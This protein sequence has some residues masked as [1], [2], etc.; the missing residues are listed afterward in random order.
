MP[1]RFMQ[2]TST[3]QQNAA[4]QLVDGTPSPIEQN[5]E[6]RAQY[7]QA[8][9]DQRL[10]VVIGVAGITQAGKST[11]TDALVEEHGFVPAT[12]LLPRTLRDNEGDG[13]KPWVSTEI[14]AKISTSNSEVPARFDTTPPKEILL[15]DQAFSGLY[16]ISA[17]NVAEQ[18]LKG[19]ST[20]VI[21]GR[22]EENYL[23]HEGARE[24]IPLVPI[25]VIQLEVPLKI[26]R[27]R[28]LNAG[29]IDPA[30]VSK[31]LQAMEDFEIGDQ[32]Q[33][34][35]LAM[36]LPVTTVMN[37][38]AAEMQTFR[39]CAG[40]IKPLGKS[41]IADLVESLSAEIRS[42]AA[43]Y[44]QDLHRVRVLQYGTSVIPDSVVQV[45][46]DNL[47][48]ALNQNCLTPYLCGGLAVA[49][50]MLGDNQTVRPVSPDIDFVLRTDTDLG[51]SPINM[52]DRL[53]AALLDLNCAHREIK[54]GGWNPQY[55]TRQAKSEVRSSQAT[56]E[57]K[58]E[59]DCLLAIRLIPKGS[60]FCFELPLDQHA[61]F[62]RRDVVLPNGNTVPLAPLEHLLVDKLIMGRGQEIAKFDLFDCAGLL[63]RGPVDVS[64]VRRL[65]DYQRY[66]PGLDKPMQELVSKGQPIGFDELCL[67]LNVI[68]PKMKS[69]LLWANKPFAA[70]SEH[71]NGS[72]TLTLDGLKRLAMTNRLVNSL[73]R[74]LSERDAE[75]ALGAGKST[76]IADAYNQSE[77]NTQANRLKEFLLYYVEFI[78]EREELYVM[79]PA[80]DLSTKTG[81]FR[82]LEGQTRRLLG[83]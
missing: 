20:A 50:Y 67:G 58:V 53:S 6:I 48:P 9:I 23:L 31:R 73:N 5:A 37:V 4:F 38:T 33:M 41:E 71:L 61:A 7:L 35:A 21:L 39:M 46:E 72:R 56:G 24:A 79:H 80:A 62:F 69:A 47:Q 57:Q 43:A 59:L 2:H 66:A 45:L 34:A 64:L 16:A 42:E 27:H 15:A 81:F 19:R 49:L 11:I 22:A 44:A 78:L 14:A 10:P 70:E 32:R 12:K 54:D 83:L 1:E 40:Q 17:R 30:E 25:G 65:I 76:T 68:D 55:L 28:A 82:K 60:L 29:V 77:L 52:E 36:S 3:S 51:S 18:Y 75:Y 63:A 13:Y 26:L 8:L 74:I